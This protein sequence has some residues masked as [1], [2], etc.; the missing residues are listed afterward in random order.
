MNPPHLP[1]TLVADAPAL[2]ALVERLRAQPVVAFDTESNSFH[3]YRERVCLLQISTHAEDVLVDPLT[4]DV[5]PLGRVLC[6]GREI[7]MHGAD[8]DVRCLKREWGWTLPRLFDT[9][10]AA[11][12]VGR[13]GLGLSALVE[14]QFGVRLSKSSQRSDWGRRP[15]TRDQIAY[16]ALDTHYLLPLRDVLAGELEARGAADEARREFDRIAAVKP[17]ER[18]FDPEGW[19]RLKGARDLDAP[20]REVLRALWLSREAY[21]RDVDRPPFKVL[22]EQAMVEV[23]RRRPRTPEELER[24]PGVTPSV[25]RRLGGAIRDAI[26]GVAENGERPA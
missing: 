23:A 17:H 4:V 1:A 20:G 2:E 5:A 25:L 26:R 22:A 15:L 6:D 11:R 13:A 16:A 19:R 3:V 8:Y 21:A 9:M 14:H 10:A 24:V 18:V 7:V 12:R